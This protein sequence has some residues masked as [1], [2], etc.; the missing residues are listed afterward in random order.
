MMCCFCSSESEKKLR[1]Q[2]KRLKIRTLQ[3]KNIENRDVE[4]GGGG[5]A[6][7]LRVVADAVIKASDRMT[8]TG[9]G[10][11]PK[12]SGGD[13]KESTAAE[14]VKVAASSGVKAGIEMEDKKGH[15]RGASAYK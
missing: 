5:L 10:A 14:S 8:P 13:W 12:T 1:K 15:T 11:P 9:A 7:G 2:E 4:E 3:R 6:V